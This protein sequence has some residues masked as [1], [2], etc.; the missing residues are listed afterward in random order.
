MFGYSIKC[1]RRAGEKGRNVY[2]IFCLFA[3]APKY[4]I[5][6]LSRNTQKIDVNKIMLV[7]NNSLLVCKEYVIA[8]ITYNELTVDH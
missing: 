3:C 7:F 4:Q 1:V 8:S 2:H 5:Y 6:E